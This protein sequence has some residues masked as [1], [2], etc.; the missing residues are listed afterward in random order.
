M[1]CFC[2]FLRSN[3]T[4]VCKCK[5]VSG[6][7]FAQ[8]WKLENDPCLS[9][10]RQTW[11]ELSWEEAPC[12][13]A[14]PK[15]QKKILFSLSSWFY[16]VVIIKHFTKWDITLVTVQNLGVTN[17]LISWGLRLCPCMLIMWCDP[18]P[19]ILCQVAAARK[20]NKKRPDHSAMDDLWSYLV[21]SS[22]NSSPTEP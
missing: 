18:H 17:Q 14:L 4:N 15:E 21:K 10:N 8:A 2:W 5:S 1:S 20:A 16:R 11:S 6:R 9:L 7:K 12:I 19:F 3:V 22:G 13:S